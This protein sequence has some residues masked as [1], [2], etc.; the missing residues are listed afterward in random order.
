MT[1]SEKRRFLM[2][3]YSK[4]LAKAT[5]AQRAAIDWYET[6]LAELQAKC[7]HKKTYSALGTP[8]DSGC[9]TCEDC[10]KEL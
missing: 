10:G 1:V 6:Q 4:Q 2:R 7:P 5:K 9:E 8:Y 3:E